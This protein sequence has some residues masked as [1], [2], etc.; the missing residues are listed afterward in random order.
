M[1]PSRTQVM[2]V[3]RLR[4]GG[5]RAAV[6]FTHIQTCRLDNVEPHAW[7]ADVLA[8]IALND[9]AAHWGASG[10]R[11]VP[12]SALLANSASGAARVAAGCGASDRHIRL[13]VDALS[14]GR[15]RSACRARWRDDFSNSS[16]VRVDQQDIVVVEFDILKVFGGRNLS[17]HIGRQL[18]DRHRLR[19]RCTDPGHETCR[20]GLTP[21]GLDAPR[22]GLHLLICQIELRRCG[23][24]DA[25]EKRRR[26]SAAIDDLTHD[27]SPIFPRRG[28][29]RSA[30]RRHRDGV[31]IRGDELSHVEVLTGETFCSFCC[32]RPITNCWRLCRDFGRRACWSASARPSPA[33]LERTRTSGLGSILT[34]FRAQVSRAVKVRP[35]ASGYT[36]GASSYVSQMLRKIPL[37]HRM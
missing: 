3:C 33:N 5:K 27:V 4:S 31:L 21:F 6:E 22:D 19:Y 37:C 30:E 25:S 14:R 28:E 1:P 2:A 10:R 24:S 23:N 9:L 16:V 18:T 12:N 36:P 15:G 17:C 29:G 8:L 13:P 34:N 26:H 11:A 20:S 35:V 7:L 32:V